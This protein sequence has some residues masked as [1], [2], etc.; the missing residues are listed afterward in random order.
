MVGEKG[1]ILQERVW[2]E[3]VEA[4]R[5]DVPEIEQLIQR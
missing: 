2:R 3:I 5:K 1:R 4:L